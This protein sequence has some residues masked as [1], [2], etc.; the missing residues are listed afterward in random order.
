MKKIQLAALTL[1]LTGI[2]TL[3]CSCDP[4]SEIVATVVSPN[5]LIL[6]DTDSLINL[7]FSTK[8][9]VTF[10]YAIS[11]KPSWLSIEPL[12]GTIEPGTNQLKVRLKPIG[13]KKGTFRDSIT[14]ITSQSGK[15][16]IPVNLTLSG[17][18]KIRINYSDLK[19]DVFTTKLP[20]SI[21]NS[22]TGTLEWSINQLP[23]WMYM[24]PGVTRGSL[25]EGKMFNFML[26]C[27]KEM[28]TPG[29]L[30]S[31]LEINTN[32]STRTIILPVQVETPEIHQ[33]KINYDSLLYNYTDSQKQ[34][35][36]R[37]TGN[38]PIH[39]E[40][41]SAPYLQL[42]PKSGI[43][44]K[45]DS[46][47]LT[48]EL[49]NRS[50]LNTGYNLSTITLIG[51]H[52]MIT[53]PVKIN[54]YINNKWT[55]AYKPVSALYSKKTNKIIVYTAENNL[56]S[57]DPDSKTTQTLHMGQAAKCIAVD[58]TGA[59][60]VLG[61][62]NSISVVD[63][64]TMKLKKTISTPSTVEHMCIASDGWIYYF[65][66]SYIQ[67]VNLSTGFN[68]SNRTSMYSYGPMELH[69]SENYI[70]AYPRFT[71]GSFYKFSV[72]NGQVKE[73]YYKGRSTIFWLSS[74]G[75][76]MYTP[77][78][79]VLRTSDIEL[80]DLSFS[81]NFIDMKNEIILAL[82][83]SKLRNKT[84]LIPSNKPYTVRL[85]DYTYLNYQKSFAI[86]HFIAGN[87][88]S[89]SKL[90]QGEGKYLFYN[91]QINKVYVL[92]KAPSNSGIIDDWALQ[93][94]DTEN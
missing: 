94:I 66:N 9:E 15:I 42:Y 11:S 38:S 40:A 61:H 5:E 78:W 41:F 81:Q 37:N 48:I 20:I 90:F 14:I 45:G 35:C 70:Y 68:I 84:F 12:K 25:T 88:L 64:S 91:D 19:F 92:L 18:P 74:S 47:Q 55:L 53:L 7:S 32:T 54:H 60:A 56:L 44:Q 62:N 59:Y 89:T 23:E 21:D 2:Q 34:V 24:V 26:Y 36:L 8:P 83:D 10:E 72:Q 39:W 77:F 50:D 73:L 49:I 43:L 17:L 93:T 3:L 16:I 79:E 4:T 13:L 6:F 85:Y 80:E 76:R 63:L 30:E 65:N 86:E 82:C 57:I 71:S 33:M 52:S 46:V 1:I 58:N 29:L 28:L 69:T 75:E 87:S 31:T 22:G 67:A 51:T 27:K